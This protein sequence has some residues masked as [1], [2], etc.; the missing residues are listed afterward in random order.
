MKKELTDYFLHYFP[1]LSSPRYFFS[2]GTFLVAGD[3]VDEYGSAVIA[4]ALAKGYYAVVAKN[5]LGVIS[6]INYSEKQKKNIKI[7]ESSTSSYPA[8]LMEM[9]L[10]FLSGYNEVNSGVSIFLLNDAP[11]GGGISTAGSLSVLLCYIFRSFYN[12]KIS[13]DEIIRI[14]LNAE[15][16]MTGTIAHRIHPQTALTAKKENLFIF[17]GISKRFR[18]QP[19]PD[20]SIGFYLAIPEKETHVSRVELDE[21]R[22]V[23]RVCLR[24]LQ[25]RYPRMKFL[26]EMK[27]QVLTNCED[28]LQPVEVKR[29]SYVISECYRVKEIVSELRNRD[30]YSIGINMSNS[31]VSL[32]NDFNVSIP[33]IDFLVDVSRSVKG[34]LGARVTGSEYGGSVLVLLDKKVID[35]FQEKVSNYSESSASCKTSFLAVELSDGVCEIFV[36]PANSKVE[37]DIV[38][39]AE[40]SKQVMS[41][42]IPT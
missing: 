10:F 5:P 16:A 26:S 30:I 12:L 20:S 8:N 33:E 4:G 28:I 13:D 37:T 27:F 42:A 21:R 23:C 11:K 32:K 24:K 40:V 35:K 25:T 19:L 3:Y 6:V 36:S 9:V 17:E 1:G 22:E 18:Y 34:V 7:G 41:E 38:S 14:C 39:D 15:G 31:H 2:P 29:L